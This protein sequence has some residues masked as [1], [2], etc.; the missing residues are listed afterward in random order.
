L[1]YWREKC[2]IIDSYA[3]KLLIGLKS[4]KKSVDMPGFTSKNEKQTEELGMK[5]GRCLRSGDVVALFGEMGAGKTAFVRGIAA[6][7][8]VKEDVSSP[9]FSL[10]NEY[11]ARIPLCH[12]DMFRIHSWDDLESTGF[13]DYLDAGAVLVIEWSENI[14]GA[15]PADCICVE[16]K[17]GI[18]LNEREITISG[19]N[20]IDYSRC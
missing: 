16:I 8:G 5:L 14:A 6:G 4:S 15:L 18:A 19:E 11:R 3:K 9:T 10:V 2:D 1:F 20:G 12:F 13:F 17:K 7:M